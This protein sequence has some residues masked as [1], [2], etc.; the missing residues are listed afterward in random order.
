VE[1]LALAA[2]AQN[3]RVR[4]EIGFVTLE[5]KQELFAAAS[6]VALPYTAFASQSGVLHDAYGHGRPVVVTDVGA[7]GQTVREDQSGLV[8]AAGDPASLASRI[9]EA[10]EEESWSD[11][12]RSTG[13]IRRERSPERT[14][15]RLRAV[16]DVVLGR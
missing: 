13:R 12:S 11:L 5:R 2:A 8:A 10:L 7:L 9:V 1:A 14:G 3:P 15:E 16:Y 4:A 6:L